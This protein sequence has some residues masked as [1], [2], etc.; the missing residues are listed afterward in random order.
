MFEKAAKFIPQLSSLVFLI[1]LQE[2]VEKERL[3]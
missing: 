2:F 1:L 3:C